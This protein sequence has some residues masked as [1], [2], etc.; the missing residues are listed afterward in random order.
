MF[1]FSMVADNYEEFCS[2]ENTFR[3]FTDTVTALP[4]PRAQV[5]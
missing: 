4:V 2:G 5:Q 3:L 1:E